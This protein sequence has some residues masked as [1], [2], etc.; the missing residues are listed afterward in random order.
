MPIK[1]IIVESAT[2][3]QKPN[4]AILHSV[5]GVVTV[6]GGINKYSVCGKSFFK[7]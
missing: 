7:I 5:V 6:G 4:M 1:V 2:L 3:M